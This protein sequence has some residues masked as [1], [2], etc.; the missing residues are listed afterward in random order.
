MRK[1]LRSGVPVL[2]ACGVWA[3]AA[4]L[5]AGPLQANVQVGKVTFSGD[6][7]LSVYSNE[8]SGPGAASSFL[9]RHVNFDDQLSLN[10]DWQEGKDVRWSS[11]LGARFTGDPRV[12]LNRASLQ[13]LS[14][15]RFSPDRHISMGDFFGSF[16]QYSLN[17]NLKGF[18]WDEENLGGFRTGVLAGV[19]KNRWDDF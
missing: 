6:N 2:R 1:H 8:V 9:T 18:K 15:D 10:A 7:R 5:L 14:L 11:Q 19:A 4:V 16:T 17:Q 3:L 13:K 12:D